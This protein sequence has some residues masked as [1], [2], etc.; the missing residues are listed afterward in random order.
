MS[1]LV[2]YWSYIIAG[3]LLVVIVLLNAKG[4]VK[5]WLLWAVAEA[6]RYLGSGTGSIKL[7]YVY[8]MAVE[9]FPW[10][11]YVV[12]F[13]IFSAWVD[14]ALIVLK[15]ELEKNKAI[16]AYVLPVSNNYNKA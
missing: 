2:N 1:W 10:I 15:D 16:A 13:N 4:N 6:E 11:R 14:E 7:R 8:D 9:K 5:Q 3:I 12:S